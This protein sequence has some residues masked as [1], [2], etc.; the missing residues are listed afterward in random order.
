MPSTPLLQWDR[1]LTVAEGAEM[2]TDGRPVP[3]PLQWGRNLTVAEGRPAQESHQFPHNASTCRRVLPVFLGDY[4]YRPPKLYS[5]VDKVDKICQLEGPFVPL[6]AT[7]TPFGQRMVP[8]WRACLPRRQPSLSQ[9]LCSYRAGRGADWAD[10]RVEPPGASYGS[11]RGW[12]LGPCPWRSNPADNVR[13]E[14]RLAHACHRGR[15]PV[16]SL[17]HP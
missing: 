11:G 17:W 1:N 8:A 4:G 15:A 2:R 9:T 12:P 10:D 3:M 14:G 16:M 5:Q 13:H 7:P 6:W